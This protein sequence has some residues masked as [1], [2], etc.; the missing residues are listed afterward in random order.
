M[1]GLERIVLEH[2]FFAG[3]GPEFAAAISGCTR[4][5]RFAAGDPTAGA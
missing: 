2:A 1:E 4:N 3:L 5:L